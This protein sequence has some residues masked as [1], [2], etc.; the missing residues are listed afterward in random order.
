MKTLHFGIE[1]IPPSPPE[2]PVYAVSVEEL[3][4]WMALDATDP[5]LPGLISTATELCEAYTGLAFITADFRETL[6][7][8]PGSREEWWDGVREMP[9]TQIRAC[10]SIFYLHRGPVS[11]V[12]SITFYDESDDDT[13]ADPVTYY[14]DTVSRT[15]RVALR[16]GYNWPNVV[17]RV[18]NGVEVIYT[19]GFGQPGDV[20]DAIKDAIKTVAA[21]IY[22]HRGQCDMGSVIDKSGAAALLFAYKRVRL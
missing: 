2:A 20:P 11:A 1:K 15:P 18:I 21:Y 19:A 7:F 22:E 4:E 16:S 8:P 13:A 3:V 12:A 10:P 9:I 5:L 17:L 14:V 6:D